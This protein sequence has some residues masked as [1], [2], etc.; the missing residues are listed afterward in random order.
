MKSYNA[1]CHYVDFLI[2]TVN[3]IEGLTLYY[4]VLDNKELKHIYYE[5]L[6]Q[7]D[8]RNVMIKHSKFFEDKIFNSLFGNLKV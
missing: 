5:D 1:L 6:F 7:L 2:K 8:L 4:D 3:Y